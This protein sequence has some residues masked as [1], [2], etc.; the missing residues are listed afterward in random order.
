MWNVFSYSYLSIL[1]A[2]AKDAEIWGLRKTWQFTELNAL[3][4]S[5]SNTASV[6]S[7]SNIV[8]IVWIATSQLASWPA[9]TYSEPTENIIS[10]Q[11]LSLIL[12]KTLPTPMGLN[13]RFLLSETS[14][15]ARNTS[16]EFDSSLVQSFLVT[17][18]HVWRRSENDYPKFFN[19]K[20]CFQPSAS[21]PEGPDPPF[22][23]MTAFLNISASTTWNYTGCILSG[24]SDN[25]TLSWASFGRWC[26]SL[27][28]FNVCCP[29]VIFHFSYS[30]IAD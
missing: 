7:S 27:R 18:A 21:K 4:L 8:C 2:T 3:A 5:T 23:F 9:Q 29:G 30:R 17:L 24:M 16:S 1:F 11:R 6:F 15:Q 12:L 28:R 19:N 10:L 26:F 14:Q 13:P 20:I 22:V 25:I